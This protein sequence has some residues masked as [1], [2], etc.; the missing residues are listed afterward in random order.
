MTNPERIYYVYMMQSA[1]RRALYIGVTNTIEVRVAQHKKHR[2]HGFS[3]EYNAT[4]LVYFERYTDIRSAINR[5][6]QLKGWRREKKD[7]LIDKVNPTRRDLSEQ[8]F[9]TPKFGRVVQDQEEQTQGPSTP[10][11]SARDDVPE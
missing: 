1:S 6:K 3:D 8:W 10:L 9:A 4:R 11:C 7:H 2:F 5:E